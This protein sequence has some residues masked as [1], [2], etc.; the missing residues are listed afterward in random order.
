MKSIL[1]LVLLA[2]LSAVEVAAANAQETAPAT[3]PASTKL[4]L[5]LDPKILDFDHL[6]ASRM[7]YM[8]ARFRLVDDKPSAVTKEPAYAGKARYGAIRVGNGPKSTTHFAIDFVQGADY[9]LY[10]DLNQ[11]GDLTDDGMGSWEKTKDLGGGITSYMSTFVVHASWGTPV[12]EEEGGEYALFMYIRTGDNGGGYAKLSG[13]SGS[14]TLGEKT[15]Q[16]VLAENTNDGIFTVPADGDLTRRPVELYVDLDGDG[17]FQGVTKSVDGKDFKYPERFSLASPIELDGKWYLARPS[18]SGSTLTIASTAAPNE[19][20]AKAQA[21]VEVH[22]APVVGS[23]APDFT[24]QT[25]DE[26]PISLSDFKGKLV[27]LD[28]WA[29]WCGPCQASMPGL[30]KLYQGVRDQGVVVL[31][32]NVWDTKPMFDKW[33]AKNSGTTYNFTFAFDPAGRGEGNVATYKYGVQGIPT[34]YVITRDG[35]IA[36]GIVGAGN[37]A[38]LQKVL[39][40]QGVKPKPE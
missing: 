4:D 17:T 31:S 29:T 38:A 14:L 8:P 11:N 10:V 18:V 9:K 6:R 28:F 30:E 33:I 16:C 37:E 27:I 13:R 21:P 12:A 1:Q 2:T 40:E 20:L 23:D 15:Y 39:S 32:M 22:K 7:G 35:K 25:P 24:V 19:Q 5:K 34:M 3:N 26:K 36:A